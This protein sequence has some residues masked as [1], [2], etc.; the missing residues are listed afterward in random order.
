MVVD[1]E[2]QRPGPRRRRAQVDRRLAAVAA[3]FE[4]GAPGARGQR[5]LVKR[6][7]FIVGHEAD[8]VASGLQQ[9]WIHALPL[10]RAA[11]YRCRGLLSRSPARPG[12]VPRPRR[13]A[14]WR[15]SSTASACSR[16]AAP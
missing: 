15:T 13:A 6:Q 16:T 10:L 4:E 1:A 8:R 3:D 14:P 12:S 9:Q 5:L 7:A 2:E 11:G